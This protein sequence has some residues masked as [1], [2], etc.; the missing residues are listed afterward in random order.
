MRLDVRPTPPPPRAILR[1]LMWWLVACA[2]LALIFVAYT[3]PERVMDMANLVW[4]CF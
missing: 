3:A 2:L 1:R 4:G